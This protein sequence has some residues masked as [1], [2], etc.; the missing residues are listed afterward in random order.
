MFNA[1]WE[2]LSFE[3]PPVPGEGHGGWRR[4]VDTALASP[5][6]LCRWQEAPVVEQADYVVQPRS[7]V[8][9]ALPLSPRG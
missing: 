1:Y 5:D 2:P 6:D 3:L 8:V 9:L 7:V 4:M